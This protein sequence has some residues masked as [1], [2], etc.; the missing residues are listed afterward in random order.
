MNER[1]SSYGEYGQSS[2]PVLD[3]FRRN[4]NTLTNEISL[5][6]AFQEYIRD[7]LHVDEIEA[8]MLHQQMQQKGI[9][10]E[11]S[12][13]DVGCEELKNEYR[14]ALFT[15]IRP[16]YLLRHTTDEYDEW[17]QEAIGVMLADNSHHDLDICLRTNGRDATECEQGQC[18]IRVIEDETTRVHMG[19]DFISLEYIIDE[20]RMRRQA[21]ILLTHASSYGVI[22][23]RYAYSL[24]MNYRMQWKNY[25]GSLRG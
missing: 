14:I 7:E 2:S 25:F 12:D 1:Q 18:P 23:D 8:D 19:P 17:L 13:L 15:Q 16:R 20:H 5:G 22:S 21:E 3:V 24:K 4:L 11:A 6:M 10:S 9:L